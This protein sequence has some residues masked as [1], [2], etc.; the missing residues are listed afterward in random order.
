MS[1]SLIDTD[2]V[3][4]DIQHVLLPVLCAELDEDSCYMTV[5]VNEVSDEAW[6]YDDAN[7]YVAHHSSMFHSE[8]TG[9]V[10]CQ[11]FEIEFKSE[12]LKD[13][14]AF[15]RMMAHEMV[16]MMQVMR[17][18]KFDYSLPY[19]EQEHEIEAYDLQDWLLFYY[20]TRK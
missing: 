3:S 4:N 9:L 18:D 17:G 13:G 20:N 10:F 7:A 5:E 11:D 6:G 8:Q 14:T 16:H 1:H 19:A 2:F 15:K 12:L